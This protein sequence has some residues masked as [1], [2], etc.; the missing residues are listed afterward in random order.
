M[1][2]RIRRNAQKP[3]DASIATLL[4]LTLLACGSASK[5][6]APSGKPSPSS[7]DAGPNAKDAAPS[8]TPMM[9]ASVAPSCHGPGYAGSPTEQAFS[10][11][12]ATV[13]DGNGKP[14]SGLIAQ[15]CGTDICLNGTTASNGSVIIEQD[16]PKMTKPAFKYADGTAYVRFALPLSGSSIDVDL[17]KQ[18]TFPFDPPASGA[19]LVPGEPAVSNGIAL[20]VSAAV[21][22]DVLDFPTPDLQKFRAL[23]IP[24]DEVPPAVDPSFGFGMVVALTPSG[25]ALCPAAALSV[26][27]SPGW[28]A[29]ARVD[30]FLHGI[31]VA[32]EWAPYGGW[33][34]VSE[35]AVSAD[36]KTI[37]TDPDGGIPALSVIGIR[38]AK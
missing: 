26:P 9:E 35:G 19:P 17:G 37:A 15:A 31:D 18:A 12:S 25:T 5:N 16:V 34:K 1:H 23:E 4:A 22:P 24:I 36:G 14:I 7:T 13:V 8:A 30:L 33:A 38:L 10:H 6:G 20:T 21:P 28:D 3:L 2:P 27:N 11:L 29:G 32:E